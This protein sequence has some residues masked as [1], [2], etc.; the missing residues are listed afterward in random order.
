MGR[1]WPVDEVPDSAIVPSGTYT[2][3]VDT[4]SLDQSGSGKLM[5]LVQLRILD[6]PSMNGIPLFERFVVGVDGDPQAED[7]ETW[8]AP[9]HVAARRW[10][11]LCKAANVPIVG[12]LD[13]DVP[14]I[15]QATLVAQ[16]EEYT[17]PEKKRDGSP[18]SYAGQRRNRIGSF[19]SVAV[20]AGGPGARAGVRPP[21]PPKG[22]TAVVPPRTVTCRRC[23]EA[24]A[25]KDLGAHM[26]AHDNE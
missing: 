6:P 23:N 26:E 3:V 24:V 16:V 10:K 4:A 19:L 1:Q 14:A 2:V 22:S 9:S 17:E 18:N 21:V 13:L 12:D 11:R 15:Q 20:P 25:M 8:K 5:I 7:P